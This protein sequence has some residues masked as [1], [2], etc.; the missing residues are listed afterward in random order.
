MKMRKM[1]CA[2]AICGAVGFMTPAIAEEPLAQTLKLKDGTTLYLHPDGTGRMIDQ[3]GKPMK[4]SDGKQMETT[5]GRVIIMENKRIWISYGPPGK[6]GV[7]QKI[8]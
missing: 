8:D 4:M 3:H 7:M 6:G 5:D 2:L 1:L